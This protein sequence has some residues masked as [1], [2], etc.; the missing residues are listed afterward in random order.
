M[1]TVVVGFGVSTLTL[2]TFVLAFIRPEL[3]LAVM[4][5]YLTDLFSIIVG[6]LIGFVSGR[7]AGRSEKE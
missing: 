1:L 3:D 6:A 4:V 7:F 2:G 5:R